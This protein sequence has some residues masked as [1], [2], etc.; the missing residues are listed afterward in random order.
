MSDLIPEQ[1]YPRM[2]RLAVCSDCNAVEDQEE[3]DRCWSCDDGLMELVPMVEIPDGTIAVFLTPEELCEL[4]YHGH[5][6]NEAFAKFERA[7]KESGE[8]QR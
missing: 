8:E 5:V 4:G 3:E 1:M 2:T 6:G 7:L